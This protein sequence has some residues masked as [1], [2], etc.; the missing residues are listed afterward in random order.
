MA[1]TGETVDGLRECQEAGLLGTDEPFS[2]V[3]AERV[4]LIR[5]LRSRGFDTALIARTDAKDGLL[6]R[7]V[8]HM[9]PAG[10]I[11]EYTLAEA[12][13]EGALDA[14]FVRRFVEAAGLSDLGEAGGQE[15]L[16][17]VRNVAVV[18]EAGLPEEALLQLVR[19]YADSLRR[20]AEAEVRLFHFYVHERLRADGLVG[21]ELREATETAS[22][23]LL[24]LVEPTVLDFH[25]LEWRSAMRDD[26][27]MHVAQ[28]AAGTKVADVPAQLQV[29]VLFADLA[30]FTPLTEAMGDTVAAKVVDRFS[31]IVRSIVHSWQGRVVKQIGDA[32]MLVFPDPGCAVECALEIEAR[33]AS[34][35]QFP[36]VRI[37]AHWGDVLYREGDYVGA[38]VNMASRVAAAAQ[39]HELLI[40]AA[41]REEIEALPG[42]DFVALGKRALKGVVEEVDLY[43]VRRSRPGPRHRLVDPVCGMELQP[44]EVTARLDIGGGTRVFCSA[45]CLQRFVAAPDRYGS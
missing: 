11:P 26:L 2:L 38:T 20:V 8:E 3:D 27:A 5:F 9:F 41:M 43:R 18:R 13:A 12:V 36:A 34:E 1:R 22:N 45:G 16:D 14:E 29:S 33:V 39:A 23:R 24:G 25:R 7:F 30:S 6:D 10:R 15:D 42:A 31:T 37:G 28:E 40:T 21:S 44:E 35:A 4:R 17:A 19:V 32:F